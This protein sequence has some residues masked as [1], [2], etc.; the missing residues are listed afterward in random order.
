MVRKSLIL[1]IFL[2]AL[3]PFGTQAAD[4][5]ARYSVYSSGFKILSADL[6]LKE[7]T[8]SY[9]VILDTKTSGFLGWLVPWEGVF[10]SAGT[11]KSGT[12][13][14][15]KHYSSAIWKK[16][17][18]TKTYSYLED[19]RFGDLSIE[20]TYIEKQSKKV[21]PKLA[22][23]T[24][25]ILSATLNALNAL[26]C[27]SKQDIFDGKRRYELSFTK[28]GEEDLTASRYNIYGG[29]AIKCQAEITPKGGAWHKKPRGWLS[30]Q[31][32]GRQ[33]GELPSFWYAPI[34]VGNE[35]AN[36]PVK[37]VVHTKFGTLRMNLSGISE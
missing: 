26:E 3:I 29:K 16:E 28:Q 14:P 21:D 1:A 10:E 11:I 7:D 30:I 27:T 35:I 34:M 17:V 36:L 6:H 9:R 19:G 20:G 32:Q 8:S 2:N 37:L 33:R 13:T 23:F 24:T 15:Q 25:D 31:E 5:K 4:V 18:D 12:Y 22:D